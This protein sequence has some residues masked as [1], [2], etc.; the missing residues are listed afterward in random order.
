MRANESM[1]KRTDVLRAT[2]TELHNCRKMLKYE[3]QLRQLQGEW[4]KKLERVL[5]EIAEDIGSDAIDFRKFAAKVLE[6]KPKSMI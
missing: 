6:A 3:E 2:R 1:R 5:S 4:T